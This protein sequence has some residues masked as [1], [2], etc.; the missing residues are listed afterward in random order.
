VSDTWHYL[1]DDDAFPD[2]GKLA[3]Q[4][5]GWHVLVGRTEDG[6]FAVN[7]RCTHQAAL[8]S[9]GKIRRGAVMCPLHGARFE[10]AT[11]R[12]IGAAYGDLRTFPLRTQDGR[13]EICVPDTPPGFDEAPVIG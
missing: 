1:I 9:A 2:T 5:G 12:C 10:M 8:L 3:A 11:G 13:I 6:L 7:D 4:I